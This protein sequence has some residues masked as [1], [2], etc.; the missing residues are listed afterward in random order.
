[1]KT[2]ATIASLLLVSMNSI[3]QTYTIIN[4]QIGLIFTNN[5]GYGGSG[6]SFYDFDGDGWDDVSIPSQA[7]NPRFCRNNGNGTFSYFEYFF[8]IGQI[9]QLTWIDFDNDGDSDI[10]MTRF[11]SSPVLL[12]NDGNFNFTDISVSAGLIMTTERHF[13]HSWGDYNRDGYLD[14]YTCNYDSFFGIS[15]NYFYE[16]NGDGTFTE[17][18]VAL[19]IDNGAKPSF[20]SVW[21]DYDND[22]W[23]DLFVI[24]DLAANSNALYRNNGNG[25]FTDVSVAA[26]IQG[27]FDPMSIS[28]G[29][30]DKDGWFDLYMSNL[31]A[32]GNRLYRNLGNG[33][34][35]NVSMAAGASVNSFC[36]GTNWIDY[37]NDTHLDIFS[38]ASLFP[39]N[40]PSI[41]YLHVNNGNNTFSYNNMSGF[42]NSPGESYGSAVGDYNNDGYPDIAL[43]NKLPTIAQIWGSSG[44]TSKWIK[45]TLQGTVSNKNAVGSRIE[46]SAGGQT[47]YRYTMAGD[48]YLSQDSQH[49]IFGLGNL[50]E[51]DSVVVK[52]P[53]GLTETFY[54]LAS[55]MNHNLVEGSTIETSIQQTANI[56]PGD[57]V[58][59]SVPGFT[60]IQWSTGF[61][62]ENLVITE[63]G[64]YTATVL[65]G[66]IEMPFPLPVV[67]VE[68][69][70]DPQFTSE[71]SNPLCNGSL[72]GSIVIDFNE[73]Q[74]ASVVWNTGEQTFAISGL[75]EG[76]YQAQIS[77]SSGCT[78][79]LDFVLSMPDMLVAGYTPTN[80]SCF[81]GND[82]TLTIDSIAG[83]TG[84]VSFVF[85]FNPDNLVAGNYSFLIIDENG[86]DATYD[87]EISQPEE[88]VIELTAEDTPE[89]ENQGQINAN[90]SG[91]TPPYEYMWSNGSQT[92]NIDGLP[93]GSYTVWI[94]DSNQCMSFAETMV[95]SIV[96]ISEYATL[97]LNLFPNPFDQELVLSSGLSG[98]I[99][100]FSLEGKTMLTKLIL[101]VEK[102]NTSD[103]PVG[104]YF[105]RFTSQ[106]KTSVRKIVK[107]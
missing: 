82:G 72:D 41:N 7:Q 90:V 48:N 2:I 87:F 84:A 21:F 69:D 104:V 85:D 95:A 59:L 75:G 101:G 65:L 3:C 22:G 14:L 103:W 44:G 86:C 63:S 89:G 10:F 52:W 27:F 96:N 20:Q 83:G 88:I 12:E 30:Y 32:G 17:K 64:A 45:I 51:A 38:A 9:K 35:E 34:F 80:V 81:E 68:F 43:N 102:I 105:V 61:V 47:Y 73:I 57:S 39:G 74:A 49:L 92:E 58:I 78:Y 29:D 55:Q 76:E 23:P 71:F 31:P 99:Q 4:N 46:L 66:D 5:W 94:T 98:L 54:D 37:N 36:W 60:N 53:S 79:A 50:T 56:C 62:G 25:T 33:T 15:R 40:T 24:N 13:G 11:Q 77:T 1:M 26:G 19:G 91:G 97:D 70:E 8:N 106:E 16:N 28:V 42:Q 100:I 6:M 93:A 107:E 18:A 67:N